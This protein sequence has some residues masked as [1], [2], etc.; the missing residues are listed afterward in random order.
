MLILL[1]LNL[2]IRFGGV[3]GLRSLCLMKSITTDRI[4]FFKTSIPRVLDYPMH[5]DG[6]SFISNLVI[7]LYDNSLIDKM[8]AIMG[9]I[10][11]S[12]S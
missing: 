5:S 1:I 9:L 10:K 4:P 12:L 6:S 7:L 11:N 8:K 3:E 2:L